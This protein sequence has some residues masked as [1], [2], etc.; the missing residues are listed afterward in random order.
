MHVCVRL[1]LQAGPPGLPARDNPDE[2]RRRER[3]RDVAQRA[4]D[5]A[6]RDDMWGKHALQRAALRA[7]PQRL[8]AAAEAPDLAPF[9]LD[10]Q[11]L[12]QTPPEAYRTVGG[13]DGGAGS[14]DGA[15]TGTGNVPANAGNP[16]GAAGGETRGAARKRNQRAERGP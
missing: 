3:A 4:A 14:S 15:K 6:W 8:R 10:R 2:F 13:T 12:F 11:L 9:P 5:A 16:A 1:C 7:L